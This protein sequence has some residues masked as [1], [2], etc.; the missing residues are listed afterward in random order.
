MNELRKRVQSEDATSR[1]CSL[2]TETSAVYNNTVHSATSLAPSECLFGSNRAFKRAAEILQLVPG[3]LGEELREIGI[4][5]TGRALLALTAKTHQ[6]QVLDER[7]QQLEK[8]R[9]IHSFNKNDLVLLQQEDGRQR[10]LAPTLL[11]PFRIQQV[12]P[13]SRYIIE[14]CRAPA[15]TLTRHANSLVPFSARSLSEEDIQRLAAQDDGLHVIKDIIAHKIH[16]NGNTGKKSKRKKP[17]FDLL[18]RFAGFDHAVWI[19]DQGVN[20]LHNAKLKEYMEKHQL[21]RK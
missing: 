18:V 10:K 3:K 21:T 16:K 9:R 11:G 15:R 2:L 6:D 13:H 12:L 8:K 14:D 7:K 1:W 17:R 4:A 20:Q 19:G 5:P